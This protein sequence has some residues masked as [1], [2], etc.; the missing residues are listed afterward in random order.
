MGSL[1][2]FITDGHHILLTS[3]PTDDHLG[4][5]Q[6]WAVT[7]ETDVNNHKSLCNLFSFLLAGYLGV[8][9]LGH[10]VRLHLTF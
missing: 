3:L 7:C 8:E 5:F 1:I 4:C 6:T 10:V 2:L 9:L